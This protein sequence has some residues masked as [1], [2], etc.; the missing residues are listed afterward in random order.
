MWEYETALFKVE[1]KTLEGWRGDR[2]WRKAE[3]FGL[4]GVWRSHA[5]WPV[6]GPRTWRMGTCS[7]WV[8][9]FRARGVEAAV[10]CPHCRLSLLGLQSPFPA[11]P[12]T[13]PSGCPAVPSWSP[14]LLRAIWG[15][16]RPQ[17]DQA[18]RQDEDRENSAGRT[19]EQRSGDG[20]SMNAG[21]PN[22]F[23]S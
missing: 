3:S 12:H 18:P 11:S 7:A 2:S 6:A 17:W 13:L 4:C 9:L 16:L 8:S 14:D 23:Y 22:P 15:T 10:G 20:E 1:Q 5:A 19:G 21:S